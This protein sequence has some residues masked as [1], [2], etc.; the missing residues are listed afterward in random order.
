MY[1][2]ERHSPTESSTSL[3]ETVGMYLFGIYH[4]VIIIVLINMLIAMMSHSFEDI[5]V[6]P[7]ISTIDLL[8]GAR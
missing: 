1:T 2:D 3:V 6:G 8:P 4:V 7:Q 5:Q